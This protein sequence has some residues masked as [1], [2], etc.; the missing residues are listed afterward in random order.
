[1]VFLETGIVRLAELKLLFMGTCALLFWE[2]ASSPCCY[3]PVYSCWER[4]H[5][6]QDVSQRQWCSLSSGPELH[7]QSQGLSPGCLS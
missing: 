5:M 6:W 2:A 3:A 1:M 7:F 4:E